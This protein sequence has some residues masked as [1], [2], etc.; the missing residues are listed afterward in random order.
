MIVKGVKCLHPALCHLFNFGMNLD[1]EDK[2]DCGNVVDF[3]CKILSWSWL[4]MMQ[5][6]L[7]SNQGVVLQSLCAALWIGRQVCKHSNGEFIMDKRSHK[8]NLE[9]PESHTSGL[10]TV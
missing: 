7:V 6:I 8:F 4:F 3:F 10:P 9:H 2:D 1:V 5:H